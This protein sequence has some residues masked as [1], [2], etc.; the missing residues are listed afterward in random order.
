MG[1][2]KELA[3]LPVAPLRFTTWVVVQV[4]AETQ[5]REGGAGGAAQR[6]DAIEAQR[7]RGELDAREAERRQGEVIEELAGPATRR[8]DAADA[9]PAGDAPA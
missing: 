8:D 6:I 2:I 7:E 3:L 4:H 9:P 5:R 1:L